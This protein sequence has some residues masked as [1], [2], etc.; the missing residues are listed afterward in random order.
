MPWWSFSKN[1]NSELADVSIQKKRN[2]LKGIQPSASIGRVQ[3][4]QEQE[5]LAQLGV[6]H[7]EHISHWLLRCYK[8]ASTNPKKSS[9]LPS[10]PP[11]D[12]NE[13]FIIQ[14]C[15]SRFLMAVSIHAA[16]FCVFSSLKMQINNLTLSPSPQVSRSAPGWANAG[17]FQTL[18]GRDEISVVEEGRITQRSGCRCMKS[19][20]SW[21]WCLLS[22]RCQNHLQPDRKP[23]STLSSPEGDEHL[24]SSQVES[25]QKLFLLNVK[26]PT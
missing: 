10:P 26:L 7:L 2:S 8:M 24:T 19:E 12:L 17:I 23:G 21:G 15:V 6:T 1:R 20:R 14:R 4:M 9:Q 22:E 5:G 16:S 25:S 3:T 18:I 11:L 13:S